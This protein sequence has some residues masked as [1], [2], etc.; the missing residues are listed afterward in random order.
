MSASTGRALAAN[1][2]TRK[3]N[4]GGWVI[5]YL[6]VALLI[7]LAA[8][9]GSFFTYGNIHSILY[10]VSFNFFAA[11]GFTLLI[12]MGELDLSVG[13]MFGLGGALMG[14][15]IFTHALPVEAAIPLAMLVAGV[16]GLGVGLLVTAFRLNSMMV[17]IGVMMAAKGVNWMLIQRFGGRQLPRAQSGFVALEVLGV[18]WTVILMLAAAA[19][20]EIF[21]VKSR[22]LRQL[23][24]IG[25]N[26]STAMLYG[27]NANAAKCVCFA[28]SAALSAFGGALM[29]ARLKHPH[30]TVGANLEIGVIT[31]AV[32]GGASI[33]GGRGSMIRTMLGVFFVFLLQNGM[34]SYNINTYVQQVIM[35]SI[36]VLAIYIDVRIN[37][38]RT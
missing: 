34:T 30:V 13:S 2:R 7:F 18:K 31:A 27:L 37:A 26:F 28:L 33:F 23:Y 19:V 35:G 9:R 22:H 4:L 16:I 12:I 5:L 17:T 36:L 3:F 20:L 24:Y 25:H 8:T 10:S 29:T 32:I 1:E 14:L 6:N 21:L 38:K 11:I 15:F